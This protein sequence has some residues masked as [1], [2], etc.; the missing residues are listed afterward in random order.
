MKL[1]LQKELQCF[2]GCSKKS[3]PF[4]ATT[5]P[6]VPGAENSQWLKLSQIN[7]AEKGEIWITKEEGEYLLMNDMWAQ[8]LQA[9]M[10]VRW[11][12]TVQPAE[13][14]CTEFRPPAAT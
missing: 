6:A 11:G 12:Q 9:G 3:L 1:V 2:S 14:D 13:M 8:Q 5:S 4:C 7:K 10:K